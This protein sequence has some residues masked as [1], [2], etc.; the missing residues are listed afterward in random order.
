MKNFWCLIKT[1]GEFI[2][3]DYAPPYIADLV[4]MTKRIA[5]NSN[6]SLCDFNIPFLIEDREKL[7]KLFS[8]QA[9][10]Q[11]I[12]SHRDRKII[13]TLLQMI[14]NLGDFIFTQSHPHN[15]HTELKLSF[16][17]SNLFFAIPFYKFIYDWFTFDVDSIQILVLF[18]KF[19]EIK[20]ASE[21]KEAAWPKFMKPMTFE[22]STVLFGSINPFRRKASA[23][24]TVKCTVNFISSN[25]EMFE[26]IKRFMRTGD[27]EWE[28]VAQKFMIN[29]QFS[30]PRNII[31][32]I[33][34]V[35]LW[36]I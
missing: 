7:L 2:K 35:R 28:N 4:G 27:F 24:P 12:T 34:S 10:E 21:T 25:N 14:K 11:A 30:C 15:R 32:E 1:V 3:R 33:K 5:K 18:V 29:F 6:V 36:F 16:M 23:A 9:F 8:Q 22:N 31:S 19:M 13:L 20:I 17:I 26:A